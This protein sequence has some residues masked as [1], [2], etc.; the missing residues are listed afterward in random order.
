[1]HSCSVIVGPFPDSLAA[2]VGASGRN[3]PGSTGPPVWVQSFALTRRGGAGGI[4]SGCAMIRSG[5]KS[6]GG[7]KN[8][9]LPFLHQNQNSS[10]LTGCCI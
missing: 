8:R 3:S 9:R 7:L 5:E 10:A 4:L 2:G 6:T 1:M